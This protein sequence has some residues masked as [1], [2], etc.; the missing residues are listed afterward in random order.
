MSVP[1]NL[2]GGLP[3]LDLKNVIM[4][5]LLAFAVLAFVSRGRLRLGATCAFAALAVSAF[6]FVW[7]RPQ[8]PERPPRRRIARLSSSARL[9]RRHKENRNALAPDEEGVPE[10][11]GPIRRRR[12]PGFPGRRSA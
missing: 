12:R 1:F 5:I 3:L 9:E 11:N 2:Q 7:A 4:V 8:H 10:P 6:L